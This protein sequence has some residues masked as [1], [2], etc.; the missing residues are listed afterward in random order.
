MNRPTILTMLIAVPLA[1]CAVGLDY[2]PKGASELGVPAAYSVEAQQA[3]QADLRQWWTAFNDPLLTQLVGQAA[4]QN[5]DVA[6]AVVRLRQAREALVQSR[7]SLL[8]DVSAS[9]GASRTEGI[10]GASGG[11]SSFSLGADVNYQADLFGGVR[12]G[13]EASRAQLEASGYDYATVL[14]SIQGE[15]A[16]N[17]ILARAAQAQLANARDSLAIQD[18]NLEIAGFRVQAGLVSSLDQE[19]ARASRAQTAASIPSIEASY[20][21]AVSRL[22]VLTGQAPGALKGEMEAVRPVPQGPGAIAV[23]IPADTLRQRPDV[24]S[25]ERNLASAV[26]Q[27]GVAEAQLYPSLSLGGSIDAGASNLGS[28][29]DVITGRVFASIAQTIFDAGR[30]RSQVRSAQAG[31]DGAF[32]AYKQTVLTAV[33]D[34]EN[35]IVALQTAQRREREFVIALDAA[36]NSAILSRSSYRAGLADFLTLSQSEASLISARNGLLQARSD[37]ASALIQLYLAL[38]GGW[39]AGAV[40]TPQ[41][42]P[43]PATLSTTGQN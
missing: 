40:P 8:P 23:G 24:R 29:F 2:R 7:A 28:I 25:A 30:T 3:A 32:V 34:V 20:N 38:G 9:A 36:N 14:V 27:I 17:Y 12:R 13:V 16:R 6:Q 19:Q 41:S 42:V 39:D 33:E 37:Q 10:T 31:A 26:A 11:N 15:I 5:L 35:A 43:A 21:S 18:D 4:T 1:G 22:G